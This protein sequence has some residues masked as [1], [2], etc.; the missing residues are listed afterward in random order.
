MLNLH[1]MK[2]ILFSFFVCFSCVTLSQDARDSY[3]INDLKIGVYTNQNNQKDTLGVFIAH[4]NKNS[5]YNLCI[6]VL[7]KKIEGS[8]SGLGIAVDATSLDRLYKNLLIAH[9]EFKNQNNQAS[10]SKNIKVGGQ[11]SVRIYQWS[12]QDK[13][14]PISRIDK[15]QNQTLY[16]ASF[17]IVNENG[18]K[19]LWIY[20]NGATTNPKEISIVFNSL[21]NINNF[22]NIISPDQVRQKHH[23][24]FRLRGKK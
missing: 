9:R 22:L 21:E 16:P 14:G 18:Q 3:I 4:P 23:N 13:N 24:H 5:A 12:S 8:Y 15:K 7:S 19:N 17:E 1:I 11:V 6:D 20:T 10:I 2:N